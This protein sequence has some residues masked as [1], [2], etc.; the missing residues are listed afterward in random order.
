M[1]HPRT[2]HASR[3]A[4]LHAAAFV[5]DDVDQDTRVVSGYL[6]PYGEVGHTTVGPVVVPEA[7]RIAIPE[8]VS[9]VKL[10]D[11]HQEPPLSVGYGVAIR[12]TPKGLRGAFRL[13]ATPDGDRVLA[14]YTA[15]E[16][17]GRARDGFSVELHAI[18]L[19]EDR[20]WPAPVLV[21]GALSAV[22]AVTTPAWANAREDGLAASRSTTITTKGNRMLTKAQKDRLL[23]LR[24]KADRTD[25]EDAEF[26]ALATIAGV[27]PESDDWT[28]ADVSAEGDE[29]DDEAEAEAEGDGEQDKDLQA[30]R[31]RAVRAPVTVKPRRTRG[32]HSLQD[33]YASQAR[34]LSGRSKPHLEAALSDIT[35]SANI[36]TAQDDYAG[37]L[38]QG[39]QY[40]RRYVPLLMPG[41]LPSYKGTGWRW[42]V[43][44]TVGDYAGDKAA[45]PSNSP[46]TEATDWTAA[47]LA[48][49]HDLDRKF[50]DFGDQEFIESY[51]DA[52]REDYA[53]KSDAKAR[54]F[55]LANAVAEGAAGGTIWHAAAV[56]AQSVFDATGGLTADY[57]LVNSGDVLDLLDVPASE[58]V[59]PEV[60]AMFGVDSDKFMPTVGVAAGTVVAGVRQA[61]RFRELSGSPIRVEAINVANGGVDGGVFGYYATEDTFTGG[62]ASATFAPA[63]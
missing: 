61:G 30:S 28:D 52:M 17:G 33:L 56:A 51:Y 25:D 37:L 38:W 20:A 36:W 50:F 1:D 34:V 32:R 41:D 24:T 8:D 22:A 47:R 15:D 11:E 40:V 53:I 12:D 10:V 58:A 39:L 18:E 4:A 45:V 26:R 23:A 27:D 31:R 57:L 42:V 9:R 2:L 3:H 43:K 59:N 49:A 5:V 44:P 62:I 21:A 13:A 60:L 16:H 55:I 54:A 46:T 48:G 63:P 7:G 29:G 6:I 14:E 19:Q 35:S